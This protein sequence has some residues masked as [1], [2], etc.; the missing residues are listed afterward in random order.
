M[1]GATH[2]R[3]WSTALLKMIGYSLADIELIEV[4]VA[5]FFDLEVLSVA[6]LEKIGLYL[7]TLIDGSCFCLT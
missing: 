5:V 3:A 4:H 2:C 1:T 6:F 7:L